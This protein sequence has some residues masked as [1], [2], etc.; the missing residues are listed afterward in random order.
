MLPNEIRNSLRETA[1]IDFH[2]KSGSSTS[3]TKAIDNIVHNAVLSN[4]E[5][6]QEEFVIKIMENI[7]ENA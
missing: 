3:R 2:I 6:F 4:P 1:K 5:C 7:K